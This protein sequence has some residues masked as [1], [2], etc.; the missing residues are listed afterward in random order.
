[1]AEIIKVEQKKTSKV[2]TVF[3]NGGSFEMPAD[4]A[5]DRGLRV[6]LCLDA[7][8]LEE[9]KAEGERRLALLRAAS[10][11]SARPISKKELRDKLVRSGIGI[12]HAKAAAERMEELGV[13]DE[14][15]FARSLVRVYAAKGYGRGRVMQ[16]FRARGVPRDIW[17]SALSDMPDPK[18]AIMRYLSRH[19]PD[20]PD[21]KEVRR[22]ADALYRRGFDWEDIRA[23]IR[24]ITDDIPEE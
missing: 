6:G 8:E 11:A 17:D 14:H 15:E 21:P 18:D 19:L 5:A 7:D 16:E 1:M 3:Y 24:G 20:H 12:E 2:V 22:A 9:L 4:M 10:Y 13:V 23:Q